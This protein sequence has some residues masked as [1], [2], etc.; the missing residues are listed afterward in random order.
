MKSKVSKKKV[1]L[2]GIITAVDWDEDDNVIAVSISTPDEEEYI[3]EDT[4]EGAEL[5]DLVFQNIR[6]T[7]VIEEDEYGDK[8]ITVES[9]EV[10]E[11]E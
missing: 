3:I 9:Y 8:I 4:P 10:L 6:V 1:T 2:T 11:E 7:G 5:L